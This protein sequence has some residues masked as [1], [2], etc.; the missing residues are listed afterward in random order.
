MAD[1]PVLVE[2]KV[3]TQDVKI[4]P[5]MVL[6]GLSA[7]EWYS[8]STDPEYLVRKIYT[9]MHAVSCVPACSDECL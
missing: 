7:F 8:G 1:R 9:A 4:T 5:E 6:A 2:E 3:E